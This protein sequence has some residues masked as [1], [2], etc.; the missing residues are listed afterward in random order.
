MSATKNH[1]TPKSRTFSKAFAF[2]L[3]VVL[4]AAGV[5]AMW[6]SPSMA[7]GVYGL[8]ATALPTTFWMY[9]YVGHRD[10]K[11]FIAAG[12]LDPTKGAPHG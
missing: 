11:E 3:S 9:V 10:L 8:M 7:L 2:Y 4:A 12:L 5:F 6:V 1:H